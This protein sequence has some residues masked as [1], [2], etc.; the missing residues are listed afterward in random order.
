MKTIRAD[1]SPESDKQAIQQT[2]GGSNIGCEKHRLAS[3]KG[4][5]SHQ[6]GQENN[7]QKEKGKKWSTFETLPHWGRKLW[8]KKSSMHGGLGE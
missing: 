4:E 1:E 7:E 5:W 6:L 2:E 8:G 3:Q